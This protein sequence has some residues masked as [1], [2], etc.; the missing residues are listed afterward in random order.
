MMVE[1]LGV[2]RA[3]Q[4]DVV[5]AGRQVR[6]E[7]G[8]LHAALAVLREDARAAQDAGAVLLDEGEA[9]VLRQ[10]LGQFLSLQLVEFRLGVEQVELAGA[11]SR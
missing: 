8:Q 3:N 11:P 9:D 1:R 10:R 6:Q 5:G 2:H 4:G 7:V